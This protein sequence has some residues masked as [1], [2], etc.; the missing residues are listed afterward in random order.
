MKTLPVF[1]LVVGLLLGLIAAVAGAQGEVAAE[2]PPTAQEVASMGEGSEEAGRLKEAAS[3]L[4]G[5]K[6]AEAREILDEVRLSL[7]NK[8]PLEC[9]VVAF[10]EE[11]P[12]SF[13]VYRTRP[14]RVFASGETMHVYAELQNY[15]ILQD[16]EVYHIFLTV[17]YNVYDSEGNHLGGENPWE[18]FRFITQRP[19]YEFF[20]RLSFDFDL[21]P[22][23]YTLEVIVKDRLAE[24]E[25]SFQL[26]F[27]RL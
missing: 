14:S 12:E 18:D 10:V 26:P 7:W 24:K 20:L 8:A 16:E 3:L 13:G 27:K 6:V 21:E 17:S 15:T 19:V 5:G 11:E 2:S 22:G 1:L 4:E 23:E 25:T 9:P